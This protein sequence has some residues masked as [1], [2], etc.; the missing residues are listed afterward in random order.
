VEV[1]LVGKSYCQLNQP[2]IISKSFLKQF[3][4][5]KN[6]N[7]LNT[8]INVI[9]KLFSSKVEV[10]FQ[11][12]FENLFLLLL[13]SSGEQ[14]QSILD[15]FLQNRAE[16]GLE[17]SVLILGHVA[18]IASDQN[19]T[20]LFKVIL[21][22]IQLIINED[23]SLAHVNY[24]G[25]YLKI[26]DCKE[27]IMNEHAQQQASNSYNALIRA[28]LI[29]SVIFI[30]LGLITY[31]LKHYPF[32]AQNLTSGKAPAPLTD[33]SDNSSENLSEA[34]IGSQTTPEITPFEVHTQEEMQ[35]EVLV[36]SKTTPEIIPET[37]E[38]YMEHGVH[39]RT[40]LIDEADLFWERDRKLDKDLWNY[41]IG[42]Y[43]PLVIG[44]AFTAGIV[45]LLRQDKY[46]RPVRK[47]LLKEDDYWFTG[48][49]Y[50]L[51]I[52]LVIKMVFTPGI[53]ALLKQYKQDK[54]ARPVRKWLLKK[55][56]IGLP[57]ASSIV[58]KEGV[59]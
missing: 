31:S 26:E 28:G 50:P 14:A 3:N 47:W 13:G 58:N 55:D 7:E 2:E 43:T 35:K 19:K 20:A 33:E 10:E 51:G 23:P 4:S 46:A 44:M 15:S 1:N 53:V 37:V 36:V 48:S 56:D 16:I 42:I 24:E 9:S 22:N 29:A 27:F 40:P 25:K 11:S 45:A 52:V 57:V 59:L 17:N 32:I 8:V 49:L 41:R 34:E 39:E 5:S 38:L 21:F 30:G 6:V 54:Y 18:R 12:F